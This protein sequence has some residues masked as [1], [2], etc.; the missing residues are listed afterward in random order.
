MKRCACSHLQLPPLTIEDKKLIKEKEKNVL[1]SNRLND[2]VT[3]S[4]TMHTDSKKIHN[5]KSNNNNKKKKNKNNNK[6]NNNNNKIITH[7]GPS[8]SLPST[9]SSSAN[10]ESTVKSYLKLRELKDRCYIKRERDLRAAHLLVTRC[11]LID[12]ETYIY[13]FRVYICIGS[14]YIYI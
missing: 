1:L 10:S 11:V 13:R 14:E 3:S 12:Y 5:N 7:D 6:N 8:S 2:I 4:S 9:S